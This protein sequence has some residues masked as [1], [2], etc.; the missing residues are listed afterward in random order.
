MS[1]GEALL[2]ALVQGLTEFLPVSSSGHLAALQNY[3][4]GFKGGDL[5]YEVLLHVGTLA[6]V[7]VYYRRDLWGMLRGLI[8]NDP[9]AAAS[10][11]LMWMVA[12]GT[13]P[14]GIIYFLFKKPIEASFGNLASI[15]AGFLLTGAVVYFTPRA[16]GGRPEALMR[17]RDAVVIGVAQGAALLPSISRSGS[18]IA[19]ALYLGLDRELAV[20][21]SFLLSIPAIVGA[22]AFEGSGIAGA[23]AAPAVYLTGTAI[24]GIVGYASIG[25]LLKLVRAG[26]LAGF[27]YY[28]WILGAAILLQ[29]MIA[30]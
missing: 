1:W 12:A 27:A 13:L 5:A 17:W 4:S 11:R 25:V 16:G 20:R 18:T 9:R 6:A 26:R 14:T 22:V 28:C 30:R 2:L 15:G 21:Y 23:G 19:A 3:I 29:Q 8:G 24:A 7:L 10:R